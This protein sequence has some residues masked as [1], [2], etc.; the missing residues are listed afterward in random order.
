MNKRIWTKF[1]NYGHGGMYVVGSLSQ[2][3]TLRTERARNR[4]AFQNC[5]DYR[6]P[7]LEIKSANYSGSK[8][9]QRHS[10]RGSF[11]C[12]IFGFWKKSELAKFAVQKSQV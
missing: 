4:A 8:K 12:A 5:T 3:A 10:V 2:T 9:I 11:H 6:R 1:G 7:T